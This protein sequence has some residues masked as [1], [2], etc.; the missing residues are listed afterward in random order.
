MWSV[1]LEAKEKAMVVVEHLKIV[2]FPSHMV[3]K[4]IMAVQLQVNMAPCVPQ[5]LMQ[6]A[7]WRN[8]LGATATAKKIVVSWKFLSFAKTL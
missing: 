1:R 7:I 8:G 4:G 2:D 6:K 5:K 3:V